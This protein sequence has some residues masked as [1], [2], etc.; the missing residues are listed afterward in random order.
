[1]RVIPP[2]ISCGL[3]RAKRV[4]LFA[5]CF[6]A[7][8]LPVIIRGGPQP[9]AGQ[10]SLEILSVLYGEKEFQVKPE[11]GPVPSA[12]GR[13]EN[14]LIRRYAVLG[15]PKEGRHL[16]IRFG[17]T[18]SDPGSFAPRIQYKLEGVDADWRDSE[19]GFM[20]MVPKFLDAN[21]IPVSRTF[22][23]VTGD[24]PGW[25]GALERS[26]LSENA[27]EAEVPPRSAWL[28]LWIDTGG[29]DENAGVWLVDELRVL[30]IAPSGEETRLLLHE[31][32][33]RGTGLDKAQGDFEIW[34]R[35]GGALE[36]AQV[37]QGPPAEGEHALLIVDEDPVDYVA[38]RLKNPNV[39]P[40]TPGTR[41]RFEWRE[42]YSIGRGRG[43]E[44]GYSDLPYGHYQFQLRVVD[45]HGY[46]TGQKLILPL[47]VSPPLYM[48][49]WFRAAVFA[50]LLVI[51]LGV[52]RLV[53]RARMRERV[54]EL[55][56]KEAVE[57][58]RA[59]I[60][61]D[62]HDDL[63]TVLSRIS[64]ASE[65]ASL[66]VVPGSSQ[67]RLLD[68]IGDASRDLTTKMQ[69]IVWAQ[70][71]VH[72]SL[73]HTASFFASFASELLNRAGIACRLDIPIDLPSLILEAEQ[74]HQLFL[75]YK[76]SLNN[77]IKHSAATEVRI[78]LHFDDSMILLVISDNGCGF[79]PEG[80]ASSNGHGLNNMQAR[81]ERIGGV[82]EVHTSPGTG[83][84]IVVS[85]PVA[86]PP[87]P[88]KRK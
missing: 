73:D 36:G 31:D 67:Q 9:E 47:V 30:E 34:V 17:A 48:N 88:R 85:L 29:Q 52:E 39:L 1:M 72:D 3:S 25:G 83:S 77:I 54:Q 26:V 65:T 8:A 53:A 19:R 75:V 38:W 86:P 40:V 44:A 61:R 63:G 50:G 70:D 87:Q 84:R 69:Q 16:E 27:W 15:L 12:S 33:E 42:V 35:D 55:E 66:G 60:A 2:H 4:F 23:R 49:V 20:H 7:F 81:M 10:Y 22:Y 18:D 62:I 14:G 58:E 51:V 37:H 78:S 45:A 11:S 46:P 82:F 41:L 64:M 71:P 56:R 74:R 80:T 32:F 5:G 68:E 6:C 57:Q 43:G 76:E 79:D 13:A 59:R 21:R 24:S 28:N